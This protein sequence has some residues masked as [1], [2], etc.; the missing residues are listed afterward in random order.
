[1]ARDEGV[2]Q[3]VDDDRVEDVVRN[4]LQPVRNPNISR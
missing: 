4:I 2:R 3:L 1:M